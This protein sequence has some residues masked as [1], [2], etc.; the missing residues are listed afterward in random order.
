MFVDPILRA[1]D[2][3]KVLATVPS[4]TPPDIR[5]HPVH[6]VRRRMPSPRMPSPRCVVNLGK[7]YPGLRVNLGLN[8]KTYPGR[9]SSL[10]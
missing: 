7:T 10:F 6:P 1:T 2:Q 3:S 5:K 4:S 9:L 8:G